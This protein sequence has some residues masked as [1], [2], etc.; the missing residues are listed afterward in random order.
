MAR[1]GGAGH[2]EVFF[3]FTKD[4]VMR[5]LKAATLVLDFDLYPRNNVDAHNV[6]CIMDAIAMG[7]ELP[8]VVID[9]KSKRII[10]GAHRV[11]AYLKLDPES[12]VM[13][14]EKNYESEAE[15][16]LDA[17]RYNA[18]HG[19][20]LDPCDR[21]RCSI[22]AERLSIPLDAVA[23]ALHMPTEKLGDL[24]QNRTANNGA[25]LA[26]ALKRTVRHMAGRKLTQAQSDANEKLSG[27]NQTFYVNQLVMLIETRMIDKDDARLMERLERLAEL[28]DELIVKV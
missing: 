4:G 3:F 26:V 24:R 10:D 15:M 12:E 9:K 18:S 20:R 8:P 16:F 17:M 25:G 2:G 1:P 14:I 19:S 7:I 6:R 5:K 13:A 11:R 28:L 23:G 22:I 27:M 21:T